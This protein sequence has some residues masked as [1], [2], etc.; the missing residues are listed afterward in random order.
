[1]NSRIQDTD[2]SAFVDNA[3]AG[4]DSQQNPTCTPDH[5]YSAF[6]CLTTHKKAQSL[7]KI[8]KLIQAAAR[9]KATASGVMLQGPV[10]QAN[11]FHPQ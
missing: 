3:S 10:I 2:Y 4:L 9:I 8:K 11:G 1:L 7:N 6:I 5:Q